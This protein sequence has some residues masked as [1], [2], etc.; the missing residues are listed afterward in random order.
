[1]EEIKS[2]FD[3]KFYLWEQQRID[4]TFVTCNKKVWEWIEQKLLESY[5]EGYNVCY[6]EYFTEE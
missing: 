3:E 2:E 6:N 5:T 4:G 1:M